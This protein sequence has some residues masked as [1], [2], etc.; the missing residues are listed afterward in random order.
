[1]VNAFGGASAFSVINDSRVQRAVVVVCLCVR[2][3][4]AHEMKSITFDFIWQDRFTALGVTK[5]RNA[6][7]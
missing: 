6:F 1:M 7:K 5:L 2:D 4:R 3:L